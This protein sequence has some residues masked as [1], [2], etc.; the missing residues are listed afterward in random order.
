[1]SIIDFT[2]IPRA[3][4]SS[5]EQDAFELFSRDLL[6]HL[7]YKILSEPS[8]GPDGGVDIIVEESRKGI[9]GETKIKWLASCKHYAHSG[10]SVGNSDEINIR[11]RVESHS[12]DGFIGVYSTLPS[13]TLLATFEG[14][15]RNIEV[16]HYD[17]AKIE[18]TLLSSANGL[19][20]AE[21]YFPESIAEWQRE[22]PV[23]AEVL[24]GLNGLQC[25]S[26]GKELLNADQK[27]GIVVLWSEFHE[28]DQIKTEE[29]YEIYWVCKGKCDFSLHPRYDRPN[30]ISGWEDIPDIC[31][32]TIYLK[33]V[34]SLVN[35]LYQGVEFSPNAIENYKTLLIET[36]PHVSRELTTNEKELLSWLM[37]LPSVAGGFDQLSE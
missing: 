2:E 23:P 4:I 27:S 36:F 12:C 25:K 21:R 19:F 28:D 11:D 29:V 34:I 8:R 15:K 6:D 7:G 26:C 20:L 17:S 32:P 33:W 5:G 35:Q 16:I 3:N 24:D 37:R 14:L 10:N 9:A 1:M 13:S 30:A 31:V 22:N 18:E